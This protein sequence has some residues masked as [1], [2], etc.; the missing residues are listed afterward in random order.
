[1]VKQLKLKDKQEATQKFYETKIREDRVS[2]K[3][4]EILANES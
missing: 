2:T 1:M 4:N 3:A